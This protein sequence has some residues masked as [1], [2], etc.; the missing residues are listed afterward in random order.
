MTRLARIA[1][2]LSSSP[3]SACS[4]PCARAGRRSPAGA[5]LRRLA[6]RRYAQVR[7]AA[8][9]LRGGTVQPAR[10]RGD[11]VRSARQDR[12]LLRR[13]VGRHLAE[14][15]DRLD[16][17]QRRRLGAQDRR[18]DDRAAALVRRPHLDQRRARV[19]LRPARALAVQ[20]G[21]PHHRRLGRRHQQFRTRHRVGARRG[22]RQGRHDQRAGDSRA[23]RRCRGIRSTPIRPAGSASITA[24]T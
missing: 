22:D 4:A 23:T 21:A 16:H 8:P 17:R 1:G 20:G 15:G 19:R 7:A 24:A 13:M 3:R 12:D 9:G 5:R 11:P 10:G 6:Q 18:P 14:A 2:P